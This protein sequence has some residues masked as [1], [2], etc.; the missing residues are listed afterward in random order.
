MPVELEFSGDIAHGRLPAAA[1]DVP[2]KPFRVERVVVQKLDALGLHLAAR[3]AVGPA[4]LQRQP[5]PGDPAGQVA[6]LPELA[7]IPTRLR[8][9]TTPADCPFPAER[10]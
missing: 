5:D 6:D 7:V 8:P 1:T 2:R 3:S 10:A 9:A 4:H